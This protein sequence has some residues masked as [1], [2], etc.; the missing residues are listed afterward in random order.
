M[1]LEIK[2]TSVAHQL[3]MLAQQSVLYEAI[4]APKPGLVDTQDCGAHQDMDIYTFVD[5]SSALYKG[6]LAFSEAGLTHEGSPRELFRAI[7]PIGM[8]C[9]KDMFTATSSVNTHK[10]IIFSMGIV[11]AATG[12]FCKEKHIAC[13][14]GLAEEESDIIF[15]IIRTMTEGLVKQDFQGLESKQQLTHGEQLYLR[16]GFTGIRG[17]AESGYPIVKD[18]ILPMLRA[19]SKDYVSRDALLLDTLLAIMSVAEDSNIVNRGGMDALEWVQQEAAAYLA[20]GGSRR[21]EARNELD[22]MNRAFIERNV[23]PGG[24]ADLLSLS[25]FLAKL[26][27]LL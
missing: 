7:R 8:E 6:F 4:L 21:S 25:I 1:M 15:K 26:E 5:S 10:G 3:A 11:L 12:R 27:R 23:S 2:R 16:Y 17:E 19:T 24:A 9:E 13:L 22:K 14:R 18:T 20:K